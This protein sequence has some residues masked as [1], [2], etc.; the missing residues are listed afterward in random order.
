MDRVVTRFWRLVDHGQVFAEQQTALVHRTDNTG[1]CFSGGGTRAQ[2]ATVGQLRALSQLGLLSEL[3]YISSVSGGSW[4]SSAFLWGSSAHEDSA[5]LGA[6]TRPEDIDLD[7][8][9]GVIP[10]DC[11]LSTATTNLEKAFWQQHKA[12]TPGPRL[13]TEAVGAV[14]LAPFGLHSADAPAH[15]V[16]DSAR[17]S[18]TVSRNPGLAGAP[19]VSPRAPQRLPFHVINGCYLGPA[20]LEP[21][22]HEAPVSFELTAL[23]GGNPQRVQQHFRSRDGRRQEAVMGGGYIEPVAL[24]APQLESMDAV[25]QTAAMAAP[26]RP[27]TLADA[28][29]ISSAAF[30]G[31]SS[32]L[33][34]STRILGG[35]TPQLEQ[36][37]I[38]PGATG[39]RAAMGDGG[40]LENYGLLTLL[41]RGVDRVVVF[42]NTSTPLDPS[43]RA[44]DAAPT[45][46]DV[47]C[48]MPPLF[49]FPVHGV[50]MALQNNQV[51]AQADWAPVVTAMQQA[52]EQGRPVVVRS[53]HEVLE[54]R[55]WGIAGG[56]RVEVLWC[57]LERVKAWEDRLSPSVERVV[58]RGS[59][60]FFKGELASFPHYKT[61][62]EDGLVDVHLSSLQARMLADFSC[63]V[64]QMV[65]DEMRAVL[66]RRSG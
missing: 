5:L 63:E 66:A 65:A 24:G 61:A 46:D 47:D 35:L 64:V 21:L 54:N 34:K 44:V 2:C 55:L 30:A 53:T 60:R 15:I 20:A 43:Y 57:Y 10:A 56:R 39:E 16:A 6:H 19:T 62:G 50:G 33:T 11:I 32:E 40:V 13:W 51:F 37:P 18:A 17:W 7:E 36:C 22:V 14:Y 41:R 45:A 29:G 59:R 28:V 3:R 27:F 25:T 31:V 8:L 38:E 48:F 49:G 1:V 4:A 26:R 9:K 42:I 23:Y 52:Q 12:G 58:D